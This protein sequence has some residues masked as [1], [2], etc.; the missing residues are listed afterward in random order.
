MMFWPT[1]EHNAAIEGSKF[2]FQESHIPSEPG[3][4]GA[5]GWV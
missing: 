2:F 3:M 4:M 1:L 5:W